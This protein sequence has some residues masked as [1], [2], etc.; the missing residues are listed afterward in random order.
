M[1]KI[2]VNPDLCTGCETCALICSHY[3][4]GGFNPHRA[5]LTIEHFKQGVFNSLSFCQQCEDAVCSKVCPTNAL[6][7]D[8]E[9][10]YI[11][12]DKNK[13][14][15]CHLCE[16]N[17]PVNAI[18]RELKINN[19]DCTRCNTCIEVCPVDAIRRVKR[20]GGCDE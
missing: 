3:N 16:K 10:G 13:C 19:D 12:L 15:E 9:K 8:R 6:E 17:C 1:K 7:I 5:C 18:S 14:I 4:L 2:V 11:T 20:G